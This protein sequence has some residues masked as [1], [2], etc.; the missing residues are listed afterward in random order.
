ME[1][2]EKKPI[3]YWNIKENVLAEALE[4]ET[5][6]SFKKNSGGACWSA[7]KNGWYEEATAHMNRLL[8]PDGY[9]KV[10]VNVLTEALKFET[11]R[12][13]KNKSYRAC[14]SAKENGWYEE[15]CSHM[16]SDIKPHHYWTLE[17]VRKE[18]L[19]FDNKQDFKK[20]NLGAYGSAIRNGWYEDV[21]KHM[22]PQGNLIRRYIYQVT[23][24]DGAIYIGLTFNFK[25]RINQ[26]L[27]SE[28]SSVYQYKT[29]TGLEPTFE[30]ISELLPKEEAVKL[31][32]KLIEEYRGSNKVFLNR[33]K[34]GGLGAGRTIWTFEV[35][36]EEAL[37][38]STKGE[39]D[40]KCNGA[41][42]AAIRNNWI[43]LICKHMDTF[44]RP[45]GYWQLK[46]NVLSEALKYDSKSAFYTNCRE[47]YHK[48]LKNGWWDEASKHMSSRV[49][50]LEKIKEEALKYN[51]RKEFSNG[52][53]GAY[54]AALKKGWM[55]EVCGHMKKIVTSRIKKPPFL[56]S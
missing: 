52:N 49:W 22:V 39:F 23:F 28:K 32:S 55:D 11:R 31:E 41:Y 46:E 42:K 6:I 2:K 38:Y 16:I 27:S 33:H 3:G 47:G 17:R 34:G 20:Y 48:A 18:A 36:K 24:P 19:K 10:K 13:F 15:A 44:S 45:K 43:N 30:I 35:V 29:E 54:S 56:R 40:E 12:D 9:W 1:K 21:S 5:R 37:K 25:K 50:T 7:K 51:S 14:L 26:H 4:H 53:S 8:K